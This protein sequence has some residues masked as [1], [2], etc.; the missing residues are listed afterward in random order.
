MTAVQEET[1]ANVF[2]SSAVHQTENPNKWVER[3]EFSSINQREESVDEY[4]DRLESKAERCD[5]GTNQ[6]ERILEQIIKGVKWRSEIKNLVDEPNLTLKLAIES[7]RTYEATIESTTCY[8]SDEG[9]TDSC[10]E[11]T[12]KNIRSCG[13][14]GKNHG[15]RKKRLL[16]V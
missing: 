12:V 14:C 5:F 9:K 8:D 7:I 11:E 10:H 4:L 16:C 15:K 6:E 13:R 2:R 3:L 1:S